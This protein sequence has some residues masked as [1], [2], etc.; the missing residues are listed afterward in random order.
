[1][2]TD[3]AT[4]SHTITPLV[5]AGEELYSTIS[6]K[7]LS[8]NAIKVSTGVATLLDGLFPTVSGLVS[9]DLNGVLVGTT[10]ILSGLNAAVTAAKTKQA[11][12][13]DAIQ[14]PTA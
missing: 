2:T 11:D 3:V 10:D 7:G 8:E 9:F 6:G 13:T 12:E 4:N 14:T 5:S 1:M